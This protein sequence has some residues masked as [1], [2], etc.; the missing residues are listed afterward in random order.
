LGEEV[1]EE[2]GREEEGVGERE[3]GLVEMGKVKAGMEVGEEDWEGALVE[4]E[5]WVG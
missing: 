3:E 5:D 2:G 4:T 1:A